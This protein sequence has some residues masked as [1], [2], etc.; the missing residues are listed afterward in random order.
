MTHA[1]RAFEGGFADPV[2]DAQK[3]FRAVMDAMANPGRI[4][5][6]S[7]L[8][9][10]PLP[11]SAEAGAIAVALFDHD[12]R[13]WSDKAISSNAE[14]KAWLTFQTGL[15]LTNDPSEAQ[16]ALV[17]D[18]AHMPALDVFARGSSE[19]PDRSTTIILQISAFDGKERLALTGPGINGVSHMAPDRL[20][21]RFVEQWTANRA[22]FPRGVDLV[23]VAKGAIAALPRTTRI[24]KVEG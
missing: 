14:A 2:F 3:T 21:A 19:Y 13:V 1:A 5:P 16:F 22:L 20:P 4:L 17:S 9:Q 8:T 7:D 23:F 10:P 6:V 12:T 11:L 18:V 15:A 24:S